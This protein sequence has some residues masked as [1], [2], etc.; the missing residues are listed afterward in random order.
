MVFAPLVLYR[1]PF[2]G[3]CERR[4]DWTGE[5]Q[6]LH[7]VGPIVR[8][9]CGMQERWRVALQHLEYLDEQLWWETVHDWAHARVGV[10][11]A[12]VDKGESSSAVVGCS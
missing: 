3:S 1:K 11:R 2:S 10:S 8:D 5:E 7:N 12:A 9:E 6:A 4:Q